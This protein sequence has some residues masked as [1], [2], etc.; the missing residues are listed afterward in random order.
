MLLCCWRLKRSQDDT[1]KIQLKRSLAK[2]FK[3]NMSFR[4]SI[5]SLR[6]IKNGIQNCKIYVRKARWK[7]LLCFCSS[8]FYFAFSCIYFI[9]LHSIFYSSKAVDRQPKAHVLFEIF[10]QR[11]FL[12]YFYYC[13][14]G[15]IHANA[16]I[17]S[18]VQGA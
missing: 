5:Y 1:I 4:L 17:Q 10:R 3:K 12:L 9:I 16:W 6:R 8:Y 7:F 14:V 11:T 13:I 15:L 2:N 18:T